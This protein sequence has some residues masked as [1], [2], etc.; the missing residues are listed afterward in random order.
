M[1]SQ[2]VDHT[3]REAIKR[4]AWGRYFLVIRALWVTVL[5]SLSRPSF[6]SN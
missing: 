4:E 2:E 3:K 5:F 6:V 1:H